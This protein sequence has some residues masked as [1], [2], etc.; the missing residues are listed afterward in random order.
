MSERYDRAITIFSPDGRLF[1]VDYAQEAVKKGTTA[2]GVR[3]KDC[4]VIG[5][6]KKSIPI[7]QDDRTVRKIF[8]VDDHVMLA[9]AG[10]S[11]DAKVLVDYARREC[12]SYKL[13]LE[14]PVAIAHIARSIADIKQEYTQTTGRRPFGCSL[15]LGGFDDNGTPHLFK[16]EPSGVYYELLGGSIG[17]SEKQVKEYL[18][19]HYDDE[20]TKDEAAVLSLVVKA[21]T[22]VVQTGAQNI[23]IVVMTRVEEPGKPAKC[24]QRLLT[25]EEIEALIEAE[26]AQVEGAGSEQMETQ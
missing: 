7:L 17:R 14:D 2:V 22:P 16:T 21:L 3:G 6:E 26:K 8:R 5:V 12:E 18:E 20:T 9:F 24:V 1:Q 11:A 25:V 23:E 4:V 10:L 19:K 13:T 15:L